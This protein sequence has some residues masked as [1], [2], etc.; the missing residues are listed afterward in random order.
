MR[1]NRFV[2]LH[3]L[4]HKIFLHCNFYSWNNICILDPENET[5]QINDKKAFSSDPWPTVNGIYS[6]ESGTW[7]WYYI[8]QS[9]A[10]MADIVQS[11]A[12]NVRPWPIR[13]QGSRH[14]SIRSQDVRHYQSVAQIE[15]YWPIRGQ[16]GRHWP[17]R[18]K[19]RM[20]DITNQ[21]HEFII[22]TNKRPE[23]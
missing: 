10:S 19:D 22:L 8:D 9:E 12:Q 6:W 20:S 2:S 4:K 1:Y 18:S 7:G 3:K 5:D 13:S 17:I 11:E 15:L 21:W 16:D 14:W 23:N